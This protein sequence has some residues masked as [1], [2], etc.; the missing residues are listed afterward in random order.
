MQSCGVGLYDDFIELEAGALDDLQ[1]RLNSEG[2]V[3]RHADGNQG[4]SHGRFSRL[5]SLLSISGSLPS[6]RGGTKGNAPSSCQL[7]T[8]NPSSGAPSV[9]RTVQSLCLLLCM[10]SGTFGTQVHHEQLENIRCD[11]SLFGFLRKAHV[12]RR[13]KLQRALSLHSVISIKLI[14][15][16]DHYYRR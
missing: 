5:N 8:H 7:P 13:N 3:R 6:I 10:K 11:R 12:E 1:M 9:V 4:S 15:V 2:A 16:S 14:Q